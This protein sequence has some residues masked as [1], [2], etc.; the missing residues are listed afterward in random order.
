MSSN[1]HSRLVWGKNFS[2]GSRPQISPSASSPHVLVIGGGVIGLTTAW[3]LLDRGYFVTI[4]AKEWA[5]YGRQQRLTSQIAGALWEYPP[6]VCGQHTDAISLHKSKKWCM[7]AYRVWSAIAADPA[8]AAAA[9]VQMK[10]STFFFPRPIEEDAA[11]LAKMHEIE[12]S[13]VQGFRRDATLVQKLDI[14]PSYGA[15]DA[16]EHISPIIDTDKAMQWL[17]TLVQRKGAVLITDTIHGD[18]FEQE[19]ELRLRF[20]ADAIVNATG[21]AS[22]QTAGDDTCY[23]IR[24][25]LIRVVNDGKDFP[26]I[27]RC[28]TISIDV[29][30][31]A[32]GIV[33]IVP[34]ND[35]T[36]LLGGIA[37]RHEWRLDLT[38]DSS[39]IKEMRRRCEEFLPMLKN[40]R[41]DPDYPIS[42]GLRPFRQRNVR[43]EREL[44]RQKMRPHSRIIHSYGQG[45]AGWSL[46]FGC[47]EDVAALVEEALR[48][49]PVQ[50]MAVAEPPQIRAR[51]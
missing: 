50:P 15:V 5:S 38:P 39:I 3:V 43:V 16:Y 1:P 49:L 21:L 10:H 41:L 25:A 37:Q 35:N 11:Q 14:N 42:Q 4:V 36:L 24:G 8:L 45:G 19:D 23:P 18:L 51:L 12:R 46:A 13:G 17:M 30:N 27:T 29:T 9:G 44:R 28:M 2:L 34:R 48:D 20:G 32:N 31:T 47:A 40:A 22:A 6:A 33:Y 26:K 7:V